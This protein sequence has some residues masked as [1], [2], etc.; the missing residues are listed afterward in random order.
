[1]PL[2]V[3]QSI[4]KLCKLTLTYNMNFYLVE[5]SK[6]IKKISYNYSSFQRQFPSRSSLLRFV[7]IGPAIQ[8]CNLLTTLYETFSFPLNVPVPVCTNFKCTS[9]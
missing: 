3:N 4:E 1:M 5:M 2:F 7:N 9:S 6:S 8:E